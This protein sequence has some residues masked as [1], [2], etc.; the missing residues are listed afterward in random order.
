[1]RLRGPSSPR[2]GC[3]P[4]WRPEGPR[5]LA[6]PPE[7]PAIAPTAVAPTAAGPTAVAPTTAGPTAGPTAA[8]RPTAAAVPVGSAAA[9]VPTGTAARP[10]GTA[11]AGA[12]PGRPPGT[13][14]ARA[15][16]F[17]LPMRCLAARPGARRGDQP[18]GLLGCRP[19]GRPTAS[20]RRAADRLGG[21]HLAGRRACRPIGGPANRLAAPPGGPPNDRRGI[22]LARRGRPAIGRGRPRPNRPGGRRPCGSARPASPP[23]A[24]RPIG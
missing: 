23:R 13:V 6:R 12:C 24:A 17:G 11:A 3:H 15:Q 8:A 4:A 20:R 22:G 21:R 19:D 16:A 5:P 7:A 9:A 18:N 14:V 1:M 10:N 2:P